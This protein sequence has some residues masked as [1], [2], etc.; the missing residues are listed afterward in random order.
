MVTRSGE[1]YICECGIKLSRV[2]DLPRHKTTKNHITSMG[3]VEKNHVDSKNVEKESYV[4]EC[5][6]ILS[7][8]RDLPK[9]KATQGH[10]TFKK[11]KTLKDELK[12]KSRLSRD[13]EAKHHAH[14]WTIETAD[15]PLSKGTCAL[16]GKTQEFAN[17]LMSGSNWYRVIPAEHS[18]SG[19]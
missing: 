1:A 7:R 4:C 8:Q 9:H 19:F 13:K 10:I 12:L 3:E 6:V 17:S 16:C 5:G 18:N 2:R 11:N 15:G 14:H